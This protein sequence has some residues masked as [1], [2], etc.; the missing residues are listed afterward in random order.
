MVVLTMNSTNF[1]TSTI[2][3]LGFQELGGNYGAWFVEKYK[4]NGR[5]RI[6]GC[7]AEK[8]KLYSVEES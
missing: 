1:I 3:L 2:S 5:E 7:H 6:R 8:V 4:A